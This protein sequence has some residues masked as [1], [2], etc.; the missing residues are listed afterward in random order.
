MYLLINTI[1]KKM[2]YIFVHSF[3]LHHCYGLLSC[4]QSYDCSCMSSSLFMLNQDPA[5]E[6]SLFICFGLVQSSLSGLVQF[7][8]TCMG[9]VDFLVWPVELYIYITCFIGRSHFWTFYLADD[10]YHEGLLGSK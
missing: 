10:N 7:I 9:K 6:D 4:H 5:T 1:L 3:F 8:S 2:L